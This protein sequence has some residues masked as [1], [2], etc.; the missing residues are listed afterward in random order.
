MFITLGYAGFSFAGP[1]KS[2]N[3]VKRSA[4]KK[5]AARGAGNARFFECVIL[6]S[7]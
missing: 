6:F 7:L 5:N 3:A 2:E 1:A 4:A